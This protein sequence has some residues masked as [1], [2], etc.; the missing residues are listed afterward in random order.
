MNVPTCPSPGLDSFVGGAAGNNAGGLAAGVLSGQGNE[1]CDQGSGVAVGYENAVSSSGDS[2]YY[3]LIGAG[4]NNVET[5]NGN[6]A[7]IGAG[8]ANTIT[9]Q[10][11]A[12]GAGSSNEISGF[13]SSI[14]AGANNKLSGNWAF[15]G[16]GFAN[17]VSGNYAAV[18]G[19]EANQVSGQFATIPGGAD[20]IASASLTFAGG[21]KSYAANTGAFV[22]SDDASSAKQLKSSASN[23]FLV[24]ATGGVKLY[25]NA[26]LTTGV[27]LAPGGG[28]WASVSDRAVKRNLESVDDSA[29][30][31][32]VALLPISKWSYISERGV[33]HI[34]PMAQDFYAAFGVG[35]DNRHI[36]SID[37]DGVALA[38]IKAL[39]RNLAAK[40]RALH[41]LSHRVDVLSAEVAAIRS[42]K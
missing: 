30:L 28:S 41:D 38:A 25:S 31:D 16:A 22:W 9:Q 26:T 3:S 2:A 23:Q 27:S 7:F 36:T 5:T 19:G 24:R 4:S 37:E 8:N 39:N 15:I 6:D 33:R 42:H 14:G 40:D 10:D 12:I 21:Y 35:E 34:G 17:V 1:A 29:M 13:N 18:D 32:K 11:S 20:N